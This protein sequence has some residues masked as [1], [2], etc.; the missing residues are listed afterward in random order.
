MSLGARNVR[1]LICADEPRVLRTSYGDWLAISSRATSVRI[2]V[3]GA[4]ESEA[5][6]LFS[7]SLKRWQEINDGEAD[8]AREDFR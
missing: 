7:A 3:V 4:S 5:R 1:D 8:Q 6:A 2:G